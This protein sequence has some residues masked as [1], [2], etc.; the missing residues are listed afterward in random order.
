M[1][2]VRS[3]RGRSAALP[4]K[5]AL[6]LLAEGILAGLSRLPCQ[7]ERR[8]GGAA[9]L[10]LVPLRLRLLL[11]L[12][13]AHLTLGHAVPPGVGLPAGAGGGGIEAPPAHGFKRRLGR[14]FGRIRCGSLPFGRA[15]STPSRSDYI[16][17]LTTYCVRASDWQPCS[18][19]ACSRD[20][21]ECGARRGVLR[22]RLATV[23]PGRLGTPPAR[24]YDLAARSSL[25]GSGR[26]LPAVVGRRAPKETEARP[27]G[28]KPPRGSAERRAPRVMA[29]LR[30]MAIQGVHVPY[31]KQLGCH[32]EYI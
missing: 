3:K 14:D 32:D 22:R 21:P 7:R 17:C 16:L 31:R 6:I 2:V 30:S 24:H 13:A 18:L 28:P 1:L 20:D 9:F 19:R 5:F 23:R 11:F 10:L 27:R 25:Y 12:G 26:Q 15:Q 4:L 29:N 8:E